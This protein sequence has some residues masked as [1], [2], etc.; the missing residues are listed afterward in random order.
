VA[1]YLA[2]QAVN[3][4][5]LNDIA[6]ALL[7]AVV[8]GEG[9]VAANLLEKR[10]ANVNGVRVG[11]LLNAGGEVDAIAHKIVVFYQHV[12]KMQ[13]KAHAQWALVALPGQQQPRPN[14][15]GASHCVYRTR[16][17]DEHRVTHR[18]EQ[19]AIASRAQLVGARLPRARIG[20]ESG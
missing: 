3:A 13:T 4:D 2:T 9:R 5:R 11:R 6:E 19:T 14:A 16:K 15:H 20:N 12:S 1:G 18:L 8:E 10:G 7:A 17:F